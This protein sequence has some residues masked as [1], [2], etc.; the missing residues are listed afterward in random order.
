MVRSQ[1]SPPLSASP[2]LLCFAALVGAAA[3]ATVG[4]GQKACFQ[5][6]P[7]E[8]TCPDRSGAAE[9]FGPCT[10]IRS[11]DD[12][13]AYSG[14]LCCYAVTKSAQSDDIGCAV[15]SGS[16]NSAGSFSSGIG[17]TAVST[18]S[19]S[20][21]P[22]PDTCEFSGFCGD[23]GNGCIGCALNGPCLPQLESCASSATCTSFMNCLSQC[24]MQDQV[25]ADGCA[26]KDPDGASLYNTMI[27]CAVCKQCP[28]VCTDMASSC[29]TGQGGAGGMSGG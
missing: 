26:S 27:D 18:V 16:F 12:D 28:N 14:N 20:T 4:C 3:A 11:I 21:G 23:T 24:A 7:L 1:R 2:A 9:F 5:W 22:A 19:V 8:G 10:D 17:G 29:S 15:S 13:G 25:C 6:S